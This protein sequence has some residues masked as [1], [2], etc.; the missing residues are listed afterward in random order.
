MCIFKYT[1]QM[2]YGIHAVNQNHHSTV[3]KLIN[4]IK[5]SRK[6]RGKTLQ[7]PVISSI[8]TENDVSSHRRAQHGEIKLIK[9]DSTSCSHL[10]SCISGFQHLAAHVARSPFQLTEKL[11]GLSFSLGF[12]VRYP[13]EK[14]QAV[15]KP[16]RTIALQAKTCA[17]RL[18]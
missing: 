13:P 1:K 7:A 11:S 12:C 17:Y 10:S 3:V 6:K 14:Q 9:R 8:T 18:C 16:A 4:M 15:G 2:F 5:Q